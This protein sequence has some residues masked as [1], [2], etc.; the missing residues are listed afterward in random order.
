MKKYN[1]GATSHYTKRKWKNQ[2][3]SVIIP[4][5]FTLI[6]HHDEASIK[7]TEQ[8]ENKKD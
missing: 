7:H 6:V 4:Y 5:F 8:D 2:Q 1:F 3:W